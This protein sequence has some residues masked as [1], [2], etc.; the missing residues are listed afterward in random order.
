MLDAVR[1]A[2]HDQLCLSSEP[3]PQPRPQYRMDVRAVCSARGAT[4]DRFRPRG[5]PR[6]PL[7]PPP[8][9]APGSLLSGGWKLLR[10]ARAGPA[11]ARRGPARRPE[12]RTWCSCGPATPRQRRAS[13]A[14]WAARAAAR[15]ATVLRRDHIVRNE[16]QLGDASSRLLSTAAVIAAAQPARAVGGEPG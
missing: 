14:P 16:S 8:A 11:L 7:P 4:H 2:F 9:V 10:A 3:L 12:C 15:S 1:C 5:L 13:A 6:V